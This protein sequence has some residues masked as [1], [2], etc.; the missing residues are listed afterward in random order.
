MIM[1]LSI[2]LGTAALAVTAPALAH[3]SWHEASSKHFV[4]YSDDKPERLEEF[5]TKLEKFD[6]AVRFAR[7]MQDHPPGL[8]NRL[9][10]FV[11]SSI[12]E[13]QKLSQMNDR[14]LA[15]FYSGRA[16]GSIAFVPR[17]AGDGSKG[18][19]DPEN[20]FFMNTLI[21]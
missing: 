20:I 5:A 13:V 16:T 3:A 18:S 14:D 1:G 9:T 17:R 7:S 11:V 6:Q 2:R 12:A 4:I 8:G 21:I 19:L 15:G 10:V